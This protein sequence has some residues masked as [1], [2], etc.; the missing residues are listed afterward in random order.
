MH[1]L[2][3]RIHED[4]FLIFIVY[5][6]GIYRHVL[7]FEGTIHGSSSNCWFRFH[8]ANSSSIKGS[9]ISKPHLII[10][11]VKT[12]IWLLHTTLSFITFHLLLTTIKET[13]NPML[14]SNINFNLQCLCHHLV[15]PFKQRDILWWYHFGTFY[16]TNG[17]LF[18]PCRKLWSL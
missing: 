2:I 3:F 14:I 4:W 17:F 7:D 6:F 18:K 9:T 13:F 12:N 1:I 10:K 16:M 11:S 5:W 8:Y 15:F